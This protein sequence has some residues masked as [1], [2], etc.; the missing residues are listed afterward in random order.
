MNLN[1][2]VLTMQGERQALSEEAF[3]LSAGCFCE[4][5]RQCWVLWHEPKQVQQQL[6]Q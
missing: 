4:L 3:G 5:P 1:E 6:M 2:N